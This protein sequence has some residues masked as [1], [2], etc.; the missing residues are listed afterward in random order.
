LT[1][2]PGIGIK[3]GAAA[4]LIVGAVAVYAAVLIALDA[5]LYYLTVQED[6]TLEW[7]SFWAFLGAGFVYLRC[8]WRTDAF[9]HLWFPAALGIFCLFVAL[10]EISWGQRLIGY[11]PPEYFL[12]NNF[13]QEL[14]VH[15][16]VDTDLRKLALRVVIFGYGVA[17]PLVMLL[18]TIGI[19]LGRI[20]IVAPP[21]AFAPAFLLTGAFQ[22]VYPIR[23]TG[24]WVELMLGLC[25]LFSALALRDRDSAAV[26][27]RPEARYAIAW[28]AVLA[29][30]VGSAALSRYQRDRDPTNVIAARLELEALQRDF[31]SGNVDR[32]CGT[33]KRLYTFARQYDE[34]YLFAGEFAALARR[35][36]PEQRAAYLIDPWN[37]AYWL[38]DNCSDEAREG[39][40]LIYSAGPN[41]KRDSTKWEIRGDDIAV[42]IRDSDRQ[43]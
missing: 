10:E 13:Q 7:A 25:F 4:N 30:G 6:E 36:L 38:R 26:A 33:H 23:F 16:I 22:L 24:E 31:E 29:V 2:Y 37:N 18:P 35:G 28:A 21:V 27:L 15:N 32:W 1:D 8:A 43:P 40:T 17:L 9:A 34:D 3:V 19:R 39:I 11:R 14:N 41:R 42:V 20:G 5:D 12:E